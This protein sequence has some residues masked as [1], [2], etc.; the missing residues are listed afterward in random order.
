MGYY[1]WLSHRSNINLKNGFKA[2]T[3]FQQPTRT[4]EEYY[5]RSFIWSV[6]MSAKFIKLRKYLLQALNPRNHGT[7]L[8]LWP[9]STLNY[10]M[11][12]T[13]CQS[14]VQLIARGMSEYSLFLACNSISTLTMARIKVQDSHIAV[15]RPMQLH[16]ETCWESMM[17]NRSQCWEE[18]NQ[19][20]SCSMVADVFPGRAHTLIS[21]IFV[22]RHKR[23]TRTNDGFT[24]IPFNM[25]YCL[26]KT[27]NILAILKINI[28]L[29]SL[30]GVQMPLAL[31]TL[32]PHSGSPELLCWSST[33]NIC[34]DAFKYM[35]FIT[36]THTKKSRQYFLHEYSS[37]NS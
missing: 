19:T 8:C 6:T 9:L 12:P 26:W 36:H 2:R 27:D 35:S 22:N 34:K 33:Y 28:L 31:P 32:S 3:F 20:S 30:A 16:V 24:S 7:A 14:R 10:V 18:Q 5:S 11:L 25:I 23:N 21:L 17:A 29:P 1:Q 4:I 13:G 37:A 15:Y